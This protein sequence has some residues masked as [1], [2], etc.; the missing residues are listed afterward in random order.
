[1]KF[2]NLFAWLFLWSLMVFAAPLHSQE[3]TSPE[4]YF[5]FRPG[6]DRQMF[7][8]QKLTDYLKLLEGETDRMVMREIGTTSMGKP[9]Y[10][11]FIS[12]AQNIARLEELGEI[13]RRLARDGD[14]PEAEREQMISEG[15]VFVMATMSMHATE[16]GPSQAVPLTTYNILSGEIPEM[17]NWLDDV[18]FML[19]PSHNPDGMDLIVN[20]YN[21]NLDSPYEGSSL[22]GVYNKYV[23]HNINRDFITLTQPENQAVAD[24]YNLEW[25]PHVLVE[26]HQMGMTGARY[27]VPPNHDPIA[28]VVDETLWNWTWVFGSNMSRDMTA[29]GLSGISQ[30][31][32]FDDYWPGST[33]TSLWKNTIS[34]LTEAA[35]AQL[36]TPVYVEA[37]ELQ[38][39]GKGLSEYKKSIRMPMPWPGGWWHLGDIVEY[40]LES[41]VSIIKTG[42]HWHQEIL[43]WRNDLTR[44][45]IRLGREEPP[46]HYIIPRQQ[47]DAGEL[48]QM[49]K[50]L[51]RHGIDIYEAREDVTLG[52][53]NVLQ[54]DI[55]IPMSQ[56]FRP[57]IKEVMESQEFP[58][59]RYT[60]DGDIIRPYDIT[61]WSLP[62]HRGIT[63][64][65][66]DQYY[67]S[68]DQAIQ[69]TTADDLFAPVQLPEGNYLVFPANLN[70]SY[71]AAFSAMAKG[72]DVARS[73]NSF[74]HQGTQIPAGSF[75]I[76]QGRRN[77]Q[78]LEQIVTGLSVAPVALEEKPEAGF[79][80]IKLPRIALVEHWM[81]DMD[82]GWTRFLFD[83]YGI[84]YQVIRPGDM[85]DTDLDDQV[86]VV[87]FPD[88]GKSQLMTGR[89]ERGGQV[90]IPFYHP[91]FAKGMGK[92]GW[93]KVLA[94]IEQ[95]G[96]VLS[97]GGSVELFYGLMEPGDDIPAF[98][99]PVSD[100]AEGLK[101]QGF[102]APGSFLQVSLMGDHP[103]TLGMP[104]QIGVFHRTEPIMRTSIPVFGMD[105]RV[106][107]QFP[108]K[109]IL[110]S[111]YAEN[112]KR[113]ENLPAMVWMQKGEGQVVLYSFTPNFRGSTPVA[114]KLIFNG[115]LL[116]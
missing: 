83:Q 25:Y 34:L 78:D 48:H 105:R 50:L 31:Y 99:F 68:L 94:F 44:K 111:G 61:S 43:T 47:H 8:Y 72:I 45:Q 42:S 24:L 1:M 73:Q 52:S 21:Q 60:P 85:A 30:N 77:R 89:Y 46:Y 59:R 100:A 51:E 107:A 36:A 37:N 27:F 56:P 66:M 93:K 62:L 35:S 29:K 103:L 26:K 64:V 91:D 80:N 104:A 97:W 76:E 38:V 28:Q 15:K 17:D 101:R 10:V 81:H 22:P 12:S 115:L 32:L 4:T 92:D 87:I 96:K 18:V 57:F 39:S 2:S 79:T 63:S 69:A 112:E 33:Q 16:V 88:A 20:H 40:E 75:L 70:E 90:S 55:V 106:I 3:I 58:V 74:S 82:G 95:G 108:E 23:G 114:S 113:L 11:A 86:D 5:G 110:L 13:N 98:R 6:E 65:E 54:G 49:I 84:P 67:E 41:M 9:M 102:F 109:D 19:V 7:D 14:I 53:M 116:E 71:R